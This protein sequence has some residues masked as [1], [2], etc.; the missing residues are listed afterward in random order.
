MLQTITYSGKV[1]E[2]VTGNPL[3]DV[4]VILKDHKQGGKEVATTQTDDKGD[5]TIT[6]NV[7]VVGGRA[8]YKLI[9]ELAEYITEC[10][11]KRKLTNI[12]PLN[13]ELEKGPN[14]NPCG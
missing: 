11:N 2:Q 6:G 5:Y 4:K 12:R 10:R 3:E 13:I 9:F 7:E 8:S 14:I 1:T